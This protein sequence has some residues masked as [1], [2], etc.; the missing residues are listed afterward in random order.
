[1]IDQCLM[2]K[3]VKLNSHDFSNGEPKW[4]G[5]YLYRW[6]LKLILPSTDHIPDAPKSI[7][8]V[9]GGNLG[10]AIITLPLVH[11]VKEKFP[12]A[13]LIAIVNSQAG[14]QIVSSQDL[15]NAVYL[16]RSSA[17]KSFKNFIQYLK[18][19]LK[20][21][22]KNPDLMISNHNGGIEHLVLPFGARAR[23]GN[24]GINLLNRSIF[25]GSCYNFPVPLSGNEGWLE[26]YELV[27]NKLGI[28]NIGLPR[29]SVSY[30]VMKTEKSRLESLC[31]RDDS[32]LI[33]LQLDVSFEQPWKQWPLDKL[34]ECISKLWC[35]YKLR[36][37]LLGTHRA[38]TA[39]NRLEELLPDIPMI[40]CLGQ[41]VIEAAAVLAC[42]D[43]NL[44]NDSGLLH[45]GVSVGV[46]T[47]GIYGMTDPKKT[48]C[49]PAPHKIVR[50][51]DTFPCYD[52]SFDTLQAC[53][54]KKCLKEISVESV[55]IA[56]RSALEG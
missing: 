19:F 9:L 17:F 7:V 24:T 16:V 18:V 44:T 31:L 29:V 28:K 15:A 54:H 11:A 38:D 20:V 5:W 21:K 46:P 8:I 27:A 32:G 4:W 36:P 41:S 34:A 23:V 51:N 25:L 49:Y 37:V 50:R 2:L 3:K 35:L 42:C 39:F 48:W 10:G 55:I 30:E 12:N 43:V 26:S 22:Q 45:L 1:M 40:N 14:H 53:K 52:K 33:A 56:V 6:F 13:Y 47:V